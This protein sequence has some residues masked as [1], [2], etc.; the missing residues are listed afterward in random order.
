[1]LIRS[2]NPI[3]PPSWVRVVVARDRMGR[4]FVTVHVKGLN[5]IEAVTY[6]R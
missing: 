3:S 4:E 6:N 2:D 1:M 5:G